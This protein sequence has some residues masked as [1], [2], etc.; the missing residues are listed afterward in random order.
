VIS[1]AEELRHF[2]H[3]VNYVSF[4][5]HDEDAEEINMAIGSKMFIGHNEERTEF[6]EGAVIETKAVYRCK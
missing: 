3:S 4:Y 2:G 1:K 6:G 5:A